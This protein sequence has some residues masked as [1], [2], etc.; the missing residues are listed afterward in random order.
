MDCEPSHEAGKGPVPDRGHDGDAGCRAARGT[1][2][3][4]RAVPRTGAPPPPVRFTLQPGASRSHPDILANDFRLT[5]AGA[6]RV[7]PLAGDIEVTGRTYTRSGQGASIGEIRR[8]V[9]PGR[10][11]QIDDVLRDAAI[12][13]IENARAVLSTATPNGAFLAF[14]FV[15]DN[16]TG[17]PSLVL[18]K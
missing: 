7:T 6:L 9:P 11:E 2:R 16:R 4:D 18:A 15:I 14:A 12:P 17:D 3:R 8:R 1:P 5:G 13:A 10:S